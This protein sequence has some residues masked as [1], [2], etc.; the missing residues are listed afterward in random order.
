MSRHS[1]FTILKLRL[2]KE[3][4]IG[5]DTFITT[6]DIVYSA[7]SSNSLCNRSATAYNQKIVYYANVTDVYKQIPRLV[8]CQ[9]YFGMIN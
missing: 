7:L 5:A 2:R 9:V 3:K 6:D 4:V 1:L 8:N